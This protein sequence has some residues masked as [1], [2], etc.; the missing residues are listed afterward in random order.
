MSVTA[1]AGRGAVQDAEAASSGSGLPAYRAVPPCGAN[2]QIREI[3]AEPRRR[4]AVVAAARRLMPTA[5]LQWGSV[6]QLVKLRVDVAIRVCVIVRSDK[7]D[8][9]SA[10]GLECYDDSDRSPQVLDAHA[11]DRHWAGE[12]VSKRRAAVTRKVIDKGDEGQRLR[13]VKV[14]CLLLRTPG[15]DYLY[16]HTYTLCATSNPRRL[17]S[18]GRPR[19]H[20][21]TRRYS[22]LGPT[23]QG[24]PGPRDGARRAQANPG[25]G[26][27]NG[28]RAGHG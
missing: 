21:A 25:P 12:T 27:R 19:L 16:G 2:D 7:H 5:P 15:R 6:Q 18:E 3:V 28:Y 23:G 14:A 13:S 4:L 26:R 11:V 9:D 22:P 17:A 20:A 24:A 10:R 8:A 1:R